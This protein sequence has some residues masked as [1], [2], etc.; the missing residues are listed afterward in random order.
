MHSNVIKAKAIGNGPTSVVKRHIFAANQEAHEI[1]DAAQ[2]EASKIVSEARSKA[3]HLLE[4]AE[5]E[6]LSERLGTMEHG[7]SDCL[8]IAR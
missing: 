4:A 7:F 2:S 8:A 5:A 6:R 3:Q 1:V